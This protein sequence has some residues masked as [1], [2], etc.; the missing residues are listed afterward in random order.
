MGPATGPSATV[1]R[2]LSLL[3]VR[4]GQSVW[5]A[6]GRWQGQADPP[7]SDLGREQAFRAAG[8]VG[9]V[10]LIVASDLERAHHTALIISEAVGVGPVV[11]EPDLRERDAGEWSGLTRAEIEASWPGYLD[12]RRRPPGFED[13]DHVI[14]RTMGA[15]DRMQQEYDGAEVLGVTHGGVV[16]ALER[17]LG[18]DAG[19]LPNLAGRQFTYDRGRLLLGERLVLVEA[20]VVTVPGQI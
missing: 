14:A 20:D 6:D 13:E 10:D 7:L 12:A 4:H 9:T 18:H 3:L 2:M 19:K 15:L 17:R 5:N 1:A 11:L 8:A 16:M